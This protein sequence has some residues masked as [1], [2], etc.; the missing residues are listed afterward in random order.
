MSLSQLFSFASN[1][2]F[3]SI[4]LQINPFQP[5]VAFP[6]ETRHLICTANKMTGFY[7][8]YNI[9]LERFNMFIWL[10]PENLDLGKPIP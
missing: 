1:V 10:A 2:F 7:M 8:K 5:S 4:F 6:I 9:E 3:H